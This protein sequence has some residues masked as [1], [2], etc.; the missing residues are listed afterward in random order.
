MFSY[1]VGT[2]RK[3]MTKTT[4]RQMRQGIAVDDGLTSVVSVASLYRAGY[5]PSEEAAMGAFLLACQQGLDG[6]GKSIGEWMGLT[7]TEYDSWMRD[8]ALPPLQ[9]RYATE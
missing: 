5:F 1:Y 4:Q 2:V 6:M 7:E 3:S 9:K 8:K